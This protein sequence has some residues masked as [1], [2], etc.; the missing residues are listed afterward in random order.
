M[1]IAELKN[2][3]RNGKAPGPGYRLDAKGPG[4]QEAAIRRMVECLRPGGWLVDEDGDWGTV[5]AVDPSHPHYVSYHG[6]YRDGEWW[7]SRGYDPRSGRKLPALFERCGLENIGHVATA[8]VVC[9][10]STW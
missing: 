9:G 2:E 6:A 4:R 3:S 5:A 10:D 1:D 7:T 8:Q